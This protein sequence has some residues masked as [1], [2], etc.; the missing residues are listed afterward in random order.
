MNGIK[1]SAPTGYPQIRSEGDFFDRL[2]AAESTDP[3]KEVF[4]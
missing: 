4:I 2:L 3:S 1:H